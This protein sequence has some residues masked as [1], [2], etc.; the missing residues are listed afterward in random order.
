LLNNNKTKFIP[1]IIL[2]FIFSGYCLFASGDEV[3]NQ[4][5]MQ[6]LFGKYRLL[7]TDD[8]RL[9]YV[10]GFMGDRKES[11]LALQKAMYWCVDEFNGHN[12]YLKGYPRQYL[13]DLV[14]FGVIGVPRYDEIDFSAGS[15]HQRYT[16]KGWDFI[17]YPRN[18]KDYNFMIIWE[19]RKNLLLSTIDKIFDFQPNEMI[20]RDSFAALIYYIH[21]IGDHIGGSKSTLVNRMP[22][23]DGRRGSN[24]D[25]ANIIWELEYHIPRLFR[26]QT[27]APEYTALMDYYKKNRESNPPLVYSDN[28]S[29]DDYKKIQS[30]AEGVLNKHIENI[31]ILLKNE[32]F[33]KRVFP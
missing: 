20:K 28:L 17:D 23:N 27:N 33:F 22:L 16:H 29:D 19:K 3:H 21:I 2:L 15:E 6:V 4:Q 32:F 25:R 7:K 9:F 14:R 8:N 18:Y 24:M 10:D 5:L 26:E 11:I 30:L 1:I 12:P 31:P 13:I